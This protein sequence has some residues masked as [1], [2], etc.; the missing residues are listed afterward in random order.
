[1]ELWGFRSGIYRVYIGPWSTRSPALCS[2]QALEHLASDCNATCGCYRAQAKLLFAVCKL[3][4]SSSILVLVLIGMAYA[5]ELIVAGA[6]TGFMTF[7]D[8]FHGSDGW[9]MMAWC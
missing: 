4:P 1:M 8:S 7:T 5:E 6:L 3:R 2:L 9:T